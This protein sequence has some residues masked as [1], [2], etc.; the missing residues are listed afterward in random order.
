MPRKGASEDDR[1]A[2]FGSR[3]FDKNSCGPGVGPVQW[4]DLPELVGVHG[5]GDLL[6][7]RATAQVA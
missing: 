6:V 1:A 7:R 5:H 3:F 4:L 2:A